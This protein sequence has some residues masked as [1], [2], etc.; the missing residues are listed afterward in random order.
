MSCVA[1]GR[2]VWGQRGLVADTC[3]GEI[4]GPARR[5]ATVRLY[6]LTD[7]GVSGMSGDPPA[8]P[9]NNDG[10]PRPGNR[11]ADGRQ[12]VA[13]L[14]QAGRIQ[15]REITL[16]ASSSVRQASHLGTLGLL[17]TN[18]LYLELIPQSCA[19]SETHA[20]AR[21]TVSGKTFSL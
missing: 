16:F 14:T 7:R 9:G 11:A 20:F 1:R 5:A 2:L 17:A 3:R 4:T 15:I 6:Y 21:I 19:L 13:L 12:Q 8:V 10:T 18:C